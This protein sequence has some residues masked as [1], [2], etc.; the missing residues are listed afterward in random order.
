MS[1]DRL[2]LSGIMFLSGWIIFCGAAIFHAILR[3]NHT[4]IAGAELY[5]IYYL[6][7]I[8]PFI[9]LLFI[10]VSSIIVLK[11]VLNKRA[12]RGGV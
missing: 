3:V 8:F 1:D 12:E 9:G 4:S 7:H 2:Y 10:A 6:V 5:S 11:I